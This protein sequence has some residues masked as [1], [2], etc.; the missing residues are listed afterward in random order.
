MAAGWMAALAFLPASRFCAVSLRIFE[1]GHPLRFGWSIG[2]MRRVRDLAGAYL[3]F[4]HLRVLTLLLSTAFVPIAMESVWRMHF[5]TAVSMWIGLVMLVLNARMQLLTWNFISSKDLF[6]K[7]CIFRLG[8]CSAP[9]G[10]SG[11]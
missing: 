1:A 7:I 2:P 4:R 11:M 6:W 10:S 8:S 5:E 9:R 3:V